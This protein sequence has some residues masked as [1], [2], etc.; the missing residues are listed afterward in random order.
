MML[1]L[2]LYSKYLAFFTNL[3]IVISLFQFSQAED[4]YAV[5]QVTILMTVV[6]DYHDYHD[7]YDYHDDYHVLGS[8]DNL[9]GSRGIR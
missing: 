9:P 1:E 2:M 5:G 8:G 4:Q 7:Y 6:D 3:T